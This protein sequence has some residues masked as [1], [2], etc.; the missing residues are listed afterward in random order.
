MM[1]HIDVRTNVIRIRFDTILLI[2]KVYNIQKVTARG[3][4]STGC[5]K[6]LQQSDLIVNRT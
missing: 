6:W 5:K 4:I 2:I 1:K 3:G